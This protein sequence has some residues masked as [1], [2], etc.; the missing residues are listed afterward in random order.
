[1]FLK[2]L[3]TKSAAFSSQQGVRMDDLQATGVDDVLRNYFDNRSSRKRWH[4][5][6]LL[7]LCSLFLSVWLERNRVLHGQF[8]GFDAI[9]SNR[10]RKECENFSI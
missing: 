2:C 5:N 3:F 7:I 8:M 4:Y 1:M 9:Q 6:F 10:L